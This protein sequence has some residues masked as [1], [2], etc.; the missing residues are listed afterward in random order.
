MPIGENVEKA[1]IDTIWINLFPMLLLS[2]LS[3]SR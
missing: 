1:E 2:G 3:S